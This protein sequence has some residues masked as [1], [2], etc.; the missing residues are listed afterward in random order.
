[1][2]FT[3]VL[4][5]MFA[6]HI[7]HSTEIVA[8]RGASGA[9]PENTVAAFKMAWELGADACELDLHLTADGKIAI[10]HD[11]DTERTTGVLMRVADST[12]DDLRTLDAG[13]WKNVK[14]QGEKIPT[15]A[16][17][18]ATLPVGTQRFF[19]EIKCGPEVVPALMEELEDW[20]PRAAQ[21]CI[22]AFS[23][24]VAVESK[25]ALPWLKVYRLSSEQT[26]D[27]EPVDLTA[28]IEKTKAQGLDG[29][30]LGSKWP[31]SAAMVKRVKEA[32]LEIY[33]WT[34][35]DP[36]Q[37]KQLADLGVDGITTDEPAL[38]KSAL[39]R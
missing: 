39:G 22:I 10:L 23:E 15:L 30:D 20:K 31:W 11:V 8:H 16:D 17:S 32:G 28:L 29:L 25:K 38:L 37:G 14:Y 2:K 6:A 21:L 19:L 9:A 34:I 26:K 18:L 27:K 4:P 33:A 5:L 3:T 1:M 36:V 24:A 7:A 13:A 12:L 35:N